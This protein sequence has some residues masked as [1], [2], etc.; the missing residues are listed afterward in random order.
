MTAD[1]FPQLPIDW[2]THN[3][4]MHPGTGCW[5][6]S[7]NRPRPLSWRQARTLIATQLDID[8]VTDCALTPDCAKPSH[9]RD[10]RLVGGSA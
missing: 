8:D 4:T 9:S 3:I 10:S 1:F 5:T 7:D 6:W 2:H